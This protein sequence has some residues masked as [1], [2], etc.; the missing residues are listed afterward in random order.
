MGYSCP[1]TYNP[2]DYY[3]Q[4]LA[5]IPGLDDTSRSTIRA[6]C[7]SFNLTSTSKQ[8]DLLIQYEASLGQE[9]VEYSARNGNDPLKM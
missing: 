9:M 5:I 1:S 6:I 2:A 7:D 4:T 8:I 3:V